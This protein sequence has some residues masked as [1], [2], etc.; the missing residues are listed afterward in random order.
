M[1]K[2][3]PQKGRLVDNSKNRAELFVRLCGLFPT[4]VPTAEYL[5]RFHLRQAVAL[6][7]GTS[8][9]MLDEIYSIRL[10]KEDGT[11]VDLHADL[12]YEDAV[13]CEC[14]MSQR[15]REYAKGMGVCTITTKNS[16]GAIFSEIHFKDGNVI[17]MS[18][19]GP[20]PS[21]NASLNSDRYYGSIETIVKIQIKNAIKSGG[22][23]EERRS[24]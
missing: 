15:S 21:G 6:D 19:V 2:N 1:E 12:S 13:I 5:T 17:G 14:R 11:V 18:V 24:N 7:R 23:L 20:D 10:T 3:T 9:E 4:K 8:D 16:K 22:S